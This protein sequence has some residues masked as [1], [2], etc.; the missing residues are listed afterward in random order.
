M[1]SVERGRAKRK[2]EVA[3]RLVTAVEPALRGGAAVEELLGL[4]QKRLGKAVRFV[5][6]VEA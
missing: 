4:L 2:V 3:E 6:F 1:A 5:I